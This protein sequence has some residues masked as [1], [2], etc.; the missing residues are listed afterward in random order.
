M[1]P[2]Y[3]KWL[4]VLT[5]LWGFPFAALLLA[6]GL[7]FG[8]QRKAVKYME[9]ELASKS[10]QYNNYKLTSSSRSRAARSRQIART[11]KILEKFVTDANSLD[12]LTFKISEFASDCGVSFFKSNALDGEVFSEISN[13]YRIG[14]MTLLLDFNSSFNE[15]VK[16]INLLERHKPIVLI[17]KF[18]IATVYGDDSLHRMTIYLN[19]YVRRYPEEPEDS[20]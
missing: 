16:L 2:L 8:P 18:S 15:F 11:T 12:N 7:M 4:I 3:K 9:T 20:I 1:K 17:E 14:R 5:L 6:N 10:E 13:Y 19:I